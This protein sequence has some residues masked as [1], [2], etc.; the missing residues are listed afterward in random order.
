MLYLAM[1]QVG[2]WR[3]ARDLTAEL[4]ILRHEVA[5]CIVRSASLI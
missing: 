3:C 4:L 5:V 1:V 2:G